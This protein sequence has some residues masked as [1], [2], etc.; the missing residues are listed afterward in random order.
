M[1]LHAVQILRHRHGGIQTTPSYSLPFYSFTLGEIVE[2]TKET[3]EKAKA[4]GAAQP[5]GRGLSVGLPSP[6]RQAA[7]PIREEV[8]GPE[9]DEQSPLVKCERLTTAAQPNTPNAGQGDVKF[10]LAKSYFWIYDIKNRK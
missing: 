6:S 9:A 1:I 10:V 8:G 2:T 5:H 4:T 3:M 7:R